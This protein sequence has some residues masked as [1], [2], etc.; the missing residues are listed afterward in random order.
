MRR[1][2][3]AE[4]YYYG[5]V[6]LFPTSWSASLS[7]FLLRRLGSGA[8]IWVSLWP[9]ERAW[10]QVLTKAGQVNEIRIARISEYPFIFFQRPKGTQTDMT[11]SVTL[12]PAQL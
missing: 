2:T 1:R 6:Q 7:R 9:A 5:G 10:T 4:A 3:Q 8:T 12:S 11:V